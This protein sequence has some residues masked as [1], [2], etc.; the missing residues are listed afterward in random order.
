MITLIKTLC[1]VILCHLTNKKWKCFL[2]G[3]NIRN[4]KI[5]TGSKN[6]YME[7]NTVQD[8][9]ASKKQLR[10][11][12]LE[13]F[14][15]IQ[16]STWALHGWGDQEELFWPMESYQLTW[17][18]LIHKATGSELSSWGQDTIDVMGFTWESL[19]HPHSFS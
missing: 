4:N 2:G 10:I 12:S 6:E 13:K 15:S 5:I 9:Q 19:F 1:K 3:K 17:R 8:H 7:Q 18:M 16:H 11:I 14:R